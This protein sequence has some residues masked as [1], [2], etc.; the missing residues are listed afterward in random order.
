MT[1]PPA[2]AALTER[3]RRHSSVEGLILIGSVTGPRF[4]ADSDIDLLIILE[5]PALP[6]HVGITHLDGRLADLI[7]ATSGDLTQ[8]LDSPAPLAAP[9]WP[10][11]LAQWLRDGSIVYDRGERLAAAQERTRQ[12]TPPAPSHR[13]RTGAAF[14]LN[15]NYAQ[16]LRLAQADDPLY[17][18]AAQV[19][20]AWFGTSDLLTHTLILRGQAWQGEKAALRYLQTQEP[21]FLALYRRFLSVATPE[22][23]LEIYG[24]LVALALAPVGNPWPANAT[25]LLPDDAAPDATPGDARRFWQ[26]L[27][28]G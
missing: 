26:D 18:L 17:R 24:E 11:R 4:S 8:V 25:V 13:D 14:A 12:D 2:L 6:L 5:N 1:P 27:T 28:G 7:F 19:R 20:M 9:G 3:L 15:Y 23:K 16:T 21:D 22:A 10:G